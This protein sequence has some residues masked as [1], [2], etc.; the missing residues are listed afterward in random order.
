MSKDMKKEAKMSMLKELKKMAGDMM[1]NDIKGKMDGLKSVTVAGKDDKSIGKGLDLAKKIVGK[2]D[3]DPDSTDAKAMAEMM[4]AG[5]MSSEEEDMDCD[6]IEE[7]PEHE[8]SESPEMEQSEL[9][10]KIK[11]LQAKLNSVKK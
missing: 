11:E 2:G 6:D 9:E 8:A 4:K 3:K 1:G 7:S 10:A 5:G